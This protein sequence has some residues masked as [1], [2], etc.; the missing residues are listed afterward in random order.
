MI[1][2]IQKEVFIRNEWNLSLF[3]GGGDPLR[4]PFV[5]NIYRT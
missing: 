2:H 5:W 3:L 1:D 4:R